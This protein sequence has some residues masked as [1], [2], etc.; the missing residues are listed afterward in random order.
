MLDR[1]EEQR[2]EGGVVHGAA[3]AQEDE[4]LGL[5]EFLDLALPNASDGQSKSK[6]CGSFV[7]EGCGAHHDFSVPQYVLVASRVQHNAAGVGV[8]AMDMQDAQPPFLLGPLQHLSH[9]HTHCPQLATLKPVLAGLGVKPVSSS[10]DISPD[11]EE[12]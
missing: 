9:T 7:I 4:R 6:R 2:L 5:V 3:A 1:L 12:T 10:E 8:D 11:G